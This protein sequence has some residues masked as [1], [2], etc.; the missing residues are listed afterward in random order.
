MDQ[1][2]LAEKIESLRRCIKRI[3]DKKP[4]SIDLLMQNLDL[5]DI[6]V[7]N[8]TRAV[9]LSVDIGSHIISN[10]DELAPQTMGEVF[11]T[12]N[13]L[14]VITAETSQQLKKAVGFRNVAVHNYEAI[15][16]IIVDTICKNSLADFRRY[17]QEVSQYASL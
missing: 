5:Q 16:W 6:L 10:T 4:E 11:T 13:K 14:G 12:L 7:L 15:N 1:L 3:E 9:Q 2:I 17:S 8:L